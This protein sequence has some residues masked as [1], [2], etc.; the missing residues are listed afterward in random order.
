MFLFHLGRYMLLLKS[1]FSRPEKT[2]VY[3]RETFKEMNVKT[4]AIIPGSTLTSSW[5]GTSIKEERFIL[6]EDIAETI[7]VASNL[8]KGAC[9]EEV[10]IRPQHGQ[11]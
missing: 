10:I 7:Y 1:V 5:E 8:S 4:T 2:A 9:M 6:A 11:V 3:W